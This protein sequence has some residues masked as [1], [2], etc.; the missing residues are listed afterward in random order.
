VRTPLSNRLLLALGL[1]VSLLGCQDA[2]V[3]AKNTTPPASEVTA[4]TIPAPQ[5]STVITATPNNAAASHPQN[6]WHNAN[7][8]QIWPRSFK[9]SDGDGHGDFNGIR[10]QLPYLQ[11]LHIN[12][13]WLT[14]IFAAPSY[15]GYDFTDFYQVESDYGSMADFEQL[16]HDA[17]KANIRIILDLV[18]NHISD[19][20]DWF[21]RS[22]KGEAPYRDYFIWRADLPK[23][24]WGP[25][26][27]SS[28]I[29][30]KAVWHFDKTRNAYYY[31]AFGPSQPDLNLTHPAVVAEMKKMATFWLNKGVAGFRLDAVRYAIEQGPQQQADTAATLA[32]WQDFTA[33]VRS[34]KPDAML[35]GEAWADLPIAAK[36][37]SEGQGL[38]AGFDFEFGYKVL[39]LL[40][41]QGAVAAEFGTMSNDAAALDGAADENTAKATAAKLHP[42]QR[43][44]QARLAT[45]VPLQYF[46]PFITNHD[47]PR[48]GWQLQGNKAKAKLAA[49]M[50]FASPG[51]T[52]IYYG[53]E[54]GMTQA[55]DAEHIHRRAPMLWD[56][57]HQ[58]GFTTAKHS[59]V[60]AEQLFPPQQHNRWWAPFVS[61]QRTGAHSVADQQKDPTSVWSLYKYLL[62]I[63][64]QRPEF[65]VN[66]SYEAK[67]LDNPNLLQI[68][69]T[70][71]DNSTIFLLNLSDKSQKIPDS[72]RQPNGYVVGWSDNDTTST[73]LGPWQLRIWHK[74]S[75]TS[76][77]GA[78]TVSVIAK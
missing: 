69:R 22:A 76:S 68:S 36:Y 35:V 21:Q 43:N 12:A 6:W 64:A 13:I 54:I 11:D 38:D 32:Y 50:L 65:A 75:T 28:N 61:V 66:A 63:K 77:T 14:P 47:Q 58:A 10:Q 33:H 16:V 2:S 40:Q 26:W 52:Y 20:H 51:P 7:I 27:D 44:Y 19:Q 15:H 31:G 55:S 41:Q 56:K 74:T 5:T 72:F 70:I 42:L 67:S 18:I 57:S 39:E 25:A 59:W 62:H 4:A 73:A 8:Y 9:D 1:A 78:S 3:T 37:Y 46:S 30:P 60:E 29:D 49:A 71:A 24:G 34:I 53:E 23:D 48:V 45:K 17:A